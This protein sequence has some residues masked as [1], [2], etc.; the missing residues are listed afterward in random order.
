MIACLVLCADFLISA[1]VRS[2]AGVFFFDFN[3]TVLTT[4]MLAD[5]SVS[6]MIAYS[7]KEKSKYTGKNLIGYT[8]N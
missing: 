5:L 3:R 8:M 1:S 2:G 4:K 7:G 6:I